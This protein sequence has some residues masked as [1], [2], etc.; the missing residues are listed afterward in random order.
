MDH[1]W[2]PAC[3]GTNLV[4]SDAM[5]WKIGCSGYRYPDWKGIFYPEDTARRRWFEYYSGHFNTVELNGTYYKFP[6][7]STFR[8]WNERSPNGFSFTVKAPH[9]VAHV[10]KLADA[11]RMLTEFYNM[12][13][14]GLG[15]KLGCILFQFSGTFEY[16]PDRLKRLIEM[17]DNSVPN[18]VEFRHRSWWNADVYSRLSMANITYCGMSHPALPDNVVRTTDTVYYRL[19]GVPHL[20]NSVY[21]IPKLEQIVQEILNQGGREAFIYFNNTADA[22]AVFNAKQLQGIC[23]L[24]H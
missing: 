14:E 1:F 19:Q 3:S 20:Y 24:V 18:V 8:R 7:L 22:H 13:R 15:A 23:E 4:R 5:Q 6:R 12:A 16:T 2:G 10:K 11:Q 17:L 21:E 9:D